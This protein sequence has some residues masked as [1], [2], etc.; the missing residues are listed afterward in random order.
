[1]A[2]NSKDDSLGRHKRLIGIASAIYR[3]YT[4]KVGNARMSS[5]SECKLGQKIIYSLQGLDPIEKEVILK[6]YFSNA[7]NM[8]W[9]MG[10]YSKSTFYRLRASGTAKFLE[11]FDNYERKEYLEKERCN[12]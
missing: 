11:R 5:V 2:R 3:Y 9:W 1:M 4:D 7:N 12:Y 6:E 8:Y 10:R